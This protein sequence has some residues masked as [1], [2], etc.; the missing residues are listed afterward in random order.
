MGHVLNTKATI[1]KDFRKAIK[2]NVGY[3][4]VASQLLQ[5]IH[6][7][8]GGGS[9]M[10]PEVQ[11][12]M[13]RVGVLEAMLSMETLQ[14]AAEACLEDG[15]QLSDAARLATSAW[16]D[17]VKARIKR[18]KEQRKSMTMLGDDPLANSL[19]TLSTERFTAGQSM[20]GAAE[21]YA[22]ETV[23]GLCKSLDLLM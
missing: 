9:D 2:T 15:K 13:V 20:A 4:V 17:S 18:H 8:E 12:L 5:E 23:D 3:W 16:V 7:S 19:V 1:D 11:L 22:H 14:Q 10:S 21:F 6:T